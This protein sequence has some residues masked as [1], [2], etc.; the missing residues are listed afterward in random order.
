MNRAKGIALVIL[1]AVIYGGTPSMVKYTYAHGSNPVMMTMFRSLLPLPIILMILLIKKIPVKIPAKMLGK[2]SVIA[3]AGSTATT[4]MLNMSYH[5]IPVGMATTL[6]FVYPTFVSLLCF[7]FYKER[8]D[9]AKI[10]AL[11]IS[12]AGILCFF[13]GGAGG[14]L[15]GI[16]LA[17][18]SGLT[19]A[20]YMVAVDQWGMK[21][22]HP[23]V[24]SL[25]TCIFVS[26]YTFLYGV[27]TNQVT[28]GMS[29]LSWVYTFIVAVLVSIGANAF[30]Q[31]GIRY[32][33][34][35]TSA[36]LSMFEPITSVVCGVLILHE[37]LSGM[38]LLGCGLI[39]FA[40]YL[41]TRKRTV[42]A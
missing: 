14:S 18:S 22:M 3:L 12:S 29:S 38:K 5:Y 13:Q 16:L 26:F 36:I 10:L 30:L 34:A 19:Y 4:I 24:F 35:S 27:L 39:L 6:H 7:F 42:I 40:V 9:R 2:I 33:G 1:S 23:M 25:Y 28:F 11:F 32:T 20:F 8:I 41:L 37:S 15:A 21:D 17:L 31:V